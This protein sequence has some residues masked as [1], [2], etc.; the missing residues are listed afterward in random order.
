M[1]Y[2]KDIT[3]DG[4]TVRFYEEAD[5]VFTDD[6]D[7]IETGKHVVIALVRVDEDSRSEGIGTK[8]MQ[9]ALDQIRADG[10]ET[11]KLAAH[12]YDGYEYMD[13]LVRFYERLG[14]EADEEQPCADVLMT[15]TF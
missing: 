13:D 5:V 14:F 7:E 3:I 10:Y 1:K 2:E 15:L 6:G 4:G 11:V 8:L 12:P 9:A